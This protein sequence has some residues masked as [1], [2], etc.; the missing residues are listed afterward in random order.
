MHVSSRSAAD[1][2]F[3]QVVNF[4]EP[5][6][7]LQEQFKEG[8][9]YVTTLSWGGHANQF[10]AIIHLLHLAKILDRVAIM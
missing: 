1:G 8:I 10:L 3:A 6:D 2:W 7:V 9:N 4:A 5:Q